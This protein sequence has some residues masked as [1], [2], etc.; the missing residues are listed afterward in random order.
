MVMAGILAVLFLIMYARGGLWTKVILDPEQGSGGSLP[1]EPSEVPESSPRP[2]KTET[3]TEEST[4]TDKEEPVAAAPKESV[5]PG[6]LPPIEEDKKRPVV[7][8]KVFYNRTDPNYFIDLQMVN[9]KCDTYQS[10]PQKC[11]DWMRE[12]ESQYHVRRA[13]PLPPCDPDHP[14]YYHAYWRG[15]IG[16]GFMWILK[17]FV[18]TQNLQ[19]A[20][21]VLWIEGNHTPLTDEEIAEAFAKEQA[22]DSQGRV[23]LTPNDPK[24]LYPTVTM[25]VH[26][27]SVLE[28]RKLAPY[29]TI[30]KFVLADQL[31][32]TSGLARP[33]WD[34]Y[35]ANEEMVAA[36]KA[37]S[38]NADDKHETKVRYLDAKKRFEEIQ[39]KYAEMKHQE[40]HPVDP[41][42]LAQIPKPAFA[43]PLNMVRPGAAF[44]GIPIGDSDTVRLI[45]MYNYGG[46]YFDTDVVFLRDMRPWWY[47]PMP[48]AAAWGI[49]D[50]YNTAL[51][52]A[53]PKEPVLHKI[54]EKGIANGVKFHPSVILPMLKGWNRHLGAISAQNQLVH[55]PAAVFDCTWAWF[56]GQHDAPFLPNVVINQGLFTTHSNR[57]RE[58]AVL[59]RKIGH[60]YVSTSPIRELRTLERLW[61]GSYA[62]HVHGIG[63]KIE[64]DSWVD[65]TLDHYECFIA[66]TCM[67]QYGEYF[68]DKH[69]IK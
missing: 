16:P 8:P 38:A 63:F 34:R 48:W 33:D 62:N 32:Q 68:P 11:F 54:L 67:N 7:N 36:E 17:S 10:R 65:I 37:V 6:S 20:R 64:T 24:R 50:A 40:G 14:I 47:T 69:P 3:L 21:Y 35:V 12:N 27:K 13:Q 41:T 25:S 15:L 52:K 55:M 56:D 5:K 2:K 4:K 51:L 18:F 53:S 61:D 29:V 42:Q 23:P 26:Y 1:L 59:I 31:F 43:W 66:R 28:L 45:L 49:G 9:A 39:A 30:K 60:Q 44:D 57:A 22:G 46:I 19:C 58:F